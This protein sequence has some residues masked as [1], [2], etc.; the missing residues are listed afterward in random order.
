M[1][2]LILGMGH[3]GKALAGALRTEGH[4]VCGTT[5]TPAKVDA[6]Q[7][8]ANEVF[9]LEGKDSE[10]VAQAAANCDV[11]V[12]TVAPN[13]QKTRTKEEREQHYEEVLRDTRQ[14]LGVQQ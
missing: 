11:I 13:V 2:V 9:V 14:A 7:Q 6:L 10:A 12:V 4:S 1:N 5:T 3:V 8:H